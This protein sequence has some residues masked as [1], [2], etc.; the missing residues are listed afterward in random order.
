MTEPWRREFSE[1]HGHHL[2]AARALGPGDLVLK[3]DAFA[4]VLSDQAATRLC[5]ASFRPAQSLLKCSRCGQ[6]RCAALTQDFLSADYFVQC[7][8]FLHCVSCFAFNTVQTL[9]LS[10]QN[11]ARLKSG[12][13]SGKRFVNSISG[14]IA[15]QVYRA[16]SQSIRLYWQSYGHSTNLSCLLTV[17]FLFC[18][19][20]QRLKLEQRPRV[21]I[22]LRLPC[23]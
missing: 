14:R 1:E 3:A 13:K 9:V 22:I 6:A 16:L 18:Y 11:R 5:A 7:Y 4:A 10:A 15:A 8:Y 20:F 19:C 23:T 21:Q 2:V 12:V 17:T